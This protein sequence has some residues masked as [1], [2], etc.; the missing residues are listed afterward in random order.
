MLQKHKLLTILMLALASTLFIFTACEEDE[1]DDPAAD[2]PT[3]EGTVTDIDGNVY[4]TV[5]IGNQEWMAE[6]LKT[7]TYNNGTS[8]DLVTN[9]STWS[10]L[11][12]GAY[13]WYDNDQAQYAETYGALYNWYAVETGNLCPDGWHVPTDEEWKT[14]EMELGMSQA[15]ADDTGYRGTNEGSKLAGNA[16]LWADG[17]LINDSEFGSSGFTALPGGYRA[18]PGSFHSIGGSGAWRGATESSTNNAW[19]RFL[20]YDNGNVSRYGYGKG[21][22]FSVRCLRD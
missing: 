10:N 21:Y 1:D 15:D 12:T 13:C 17:D 11:Y 3:N 20:G 6:N 8:I 16:A 2:D 14:L 18:N 5:Q 4:S 9:S 7:T 22:G 19:Y